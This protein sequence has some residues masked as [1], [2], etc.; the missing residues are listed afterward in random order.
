MQMKNYIKLLYG[1]VLVSL[2]AGCT[3]DEF[4]KNYDIN[5]PVSEIVDF[6]PKTER[7]GNEITLYGE[8]M[9]FV[10][11]VFIGNA[12]ATIVNQDKES[13]V[14]RVPRMAEVANITVANKYKR[15]N[16]SKEVFTPQ[17][18]DVVINQWPVEI[19]RG[20]TVTITGENMDMIQSLKFESV[21][22]SKAAASET[23]ATY[24]TAGLTLPE[25]GSLIAVTKTG[26]TLTSPVISVVEP[27]TT[28]TPQ[29]TILL[30]DFETAPATADGW[31]GTPY[32]GGVVDNGFFGKAFQIKSD[33]GNGW[34]G[35]YIKLTNNN[36]GNGFNLT[37]FTSP[38]I[39]FLVNT[40]GK[41]GYMNPAITIGGSESDKHFTGQGGE[42]TDNYK[43][44][45][46][47]WEW[48]SYDLEAMGWSNIKGQVDK[49]DLWFRGGNVGSSEPFEIMIDQVMITDGPLN[50]TLI[51]DAEAPAGGDLPVTF[52]GG[53]GLTGYH[54]GEKYVTYN[55]TVGSD[56]WAWLGNIMS[57][58]VEG[59]DPGKYGNAIYLNFLVNTGDT[60]GYAGFQILQ[61]DNKLA[62]QKLDSS[63]GD[64]YKFAPTNS[65]W[66]WRSMLFDITAWDVWG[67]SAASFNLS[68]PFNFSVYAR[69]GNIASGVNAK[70]NMDYFIFT[71]VPLDA[72][73]E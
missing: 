23:S 7:V 49:I 64:N 44:T 14:I 22:L 43:I 26:Q 63:Y 56:A 55:Y 30:W 42:Y 9:Q 60:E 1:I 24:A 72:T 61:G 2:L 27:K 10:T 46:N 51:W 28:Y 8:N 54:Q 15:E 6:N 45:T 5:L 40:N 13:L 33:A 32:T 73:K 41:S 17:Y 59:L 68:Q 70:L 71:S 66:E 16:I 39:T 58:D 48:R 3:E 62:N 25:S 18:L 50:P 57:L 36:S 20:K 34:D 65:K 52:N 47:G 4:S 37:T 31:G 38:H 21:T 11:S 29:Q 35:C 19:E 67:G 12:S 53:T 69:G